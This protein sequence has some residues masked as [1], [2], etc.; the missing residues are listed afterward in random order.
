M[1][2][3]PAVV[4]L[5]SE[6]RQRSDL[7]RAWWAEQEVCDEM[8]SGHLTY[9][10]PFVGRMSFDFEVLKVLESPSLTV[11]VQVCDGAETCERL[12]ELLRQQRNGEHTPGHNLWTALAPWP[13][14]SA[15]YAG[16][17]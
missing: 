2:A 13:N 12:D 4:K 7:F 6:L 16:A 9:Q 11:Q 17:H 1:L 10:H 15:R 8:N 5:V 3:H 14:G